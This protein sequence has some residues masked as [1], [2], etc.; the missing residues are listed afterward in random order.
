MEKG[1]TSFELL[2][3]ALVVLSVSAFITTMYL[4]TNE[5]TT[6]LALTKSEL[7]TELN[8]STSNNLIQSIN[9][10]KTPSNNTQKIIVQILSTNPQE[11]RTIITS[12][13]IND[14]NSKIKDKF[15]IENQQ[16]DLT[17]RQL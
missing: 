4:Q 12:K 17:I 13:Y 15:K 11:L 2:F 7:L 9:I 8:K 6:I 16:I 3:L 1:Q 14:L 5:N 10:E